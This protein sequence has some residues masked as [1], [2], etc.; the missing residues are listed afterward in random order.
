MVQDR[1]HPAAKRGTGGARSRTRTRRG[2]RRGLRARRD[3]HTAA[4]RRRPG[5]NRAGI[6][7][8]TRSP[9]RRMC[10]LEET[11]NQPRVL[12]SIGGRTT[13]C[14]AAVDSRNDG[15][16]SHFD[17][18]DNGTPRT[19]VHL[20]PIGAQPADPA[21]VP[22]GT[23]TRNKPFPEN[24]PVTGSHRT[25]TV[26]PAGAAAP[27]LAR[28]STRETARESRRPHGSRGRAGSHDHKSDDQAG[29][30][31]FR[32]PAGRPLKRAVAGRS[33]ADTSAS[34]TSMISCAARESWMRPSGSSESGPRTV[35]R[36]RQ[37]PATRRSTV[38][39][40]TAVSASA[41]RNV[42]RTQTKGRSGSFDAQRPRAAM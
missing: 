6:A 21:S 27:R 18:A 1:A 32:R 17:R 38:S 22:R 15:H 36:Q 39:R 4:T 14:A 19:R 7:G 30:A 5:T 26:D 12:R 10:R 41:A 20:A 11:A 37:P 42:L 35:R 28:S 25:R 31:R 8:R 33:V 16:R 2:V 24:A 9:V 13:Q 34:C 23:R 29:R 3:A 40:T